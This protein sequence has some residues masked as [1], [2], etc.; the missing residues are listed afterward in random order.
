MVGSQS[1][2]RK[3]GLDQSESR[4]S[5]MWLIDVTTIVLAHVTPPEVTPQTPGSD[6]A[7]GSDL[8]TGSHSPVYRKWPRDRKW[9]HNR[10]WL[11]HRK[12][13]PSPPEVTSQPEVTVRPEVILS[14]SPQVLKVTAQPEVKKCALLYN[15]INDLYICVGCCTLT[16]VVFLCDNLQQRMRIK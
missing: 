16:L 8:A 7:T 1:E 6:R 9:H 5:P 10:K 4:I 15:A 11:C 13:L 3:F 2:R 14:T 12:S